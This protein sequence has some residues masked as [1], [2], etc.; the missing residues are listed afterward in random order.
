MTSP[1]ETPRL[2]M[3]PFAERHLTERYVGWLNDPVVVRYSE[4]RFREHSLE[5][6]RT[7]WNSYAGTPHLFWAIEVK[8]AVESHIGNINAYL[9]ANHGVADVGI[10]IG[11]REAW[12]HGYGTEA[13]IAICDHLFRE[14]GVRKITAGT[15]SLNHG[16]RSIMRKAGMEEDGCR[17]AQLLIEGEEVDVVHA[18]L[19]RDA[20]EHRPAPADRTTG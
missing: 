10:L 2:R 8:E 1:I 3:V 7:Y 6:C 5:S 15:A 18:A 13:W 16:M 9:D 14:Q 19:F 4:Q 12:G 20:W 17:R 11:A